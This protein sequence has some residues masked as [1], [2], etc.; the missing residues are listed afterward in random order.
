EFTSIYAAFLK[1]LGLKFELVGN[2]DYSKSHTSLN[3]RCGKYIV[4]ADSVLSI[5][6]SDMSYAKNGLKLTGFTLENQNL[7]TNLEFE[8]KLEKVYSYISKNQDMKYQGN[9]RQIK[10]FFNDL[11]EDMNLDT[12]VK[13]FIAMTNN[14]ELPP[15]DK[16]TYEIELK[17]KFF[18]K[19]N[20][21]KTNPR[22]VMNFLSYDDS[23]DFHE[24]YSAMTLLTFN[25]LGVNDIKTNSY[26][27][28][29]SNGAVDSYTYPEVKYQF[30]S[31][32]FS[33]TMGNNREVPGFT[34]TEMNRNFIYDPSEDN[35]TRSR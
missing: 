35:K 25:D 13:F 15:V 5:I 32:K 12:K 27:S 34:V 9:V 33:G 22:F 11:P 30:E 23:D 17:N 20:E 14:S 2:S 7:R 18:S 6:R 3:F 29:R 4:N 21:D 26:V 10:K 16:F 31:N 24:K 19:D 1:E 8:T 28:I